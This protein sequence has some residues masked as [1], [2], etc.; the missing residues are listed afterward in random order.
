MQWMTYTINERFVTYSMKASKRSPNHR[1]MRLGNHFTFSSHKKNMYIFFLSFSLFF[2][3]SFLSR[4][5]KQKNLFKINFPVREVHL[6][7]RSSCHYYFNKKIIISPLLHKIIGRKISYIFKLCIGIR[8][9]QRLLTI[10]HS[11]IIF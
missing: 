3:F 10:M 7:L 6:T 5:C 9:V 8:L 1:M 11:I 4:S 2:P